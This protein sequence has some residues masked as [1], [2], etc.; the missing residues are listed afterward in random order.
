MKP[1]AKLRRWSGLLRE[2]GRKRSNDYKDDIFALPQVNPHNRR[3]QCRVFGPAG[4][5]SVI[6]R[7]TS[8]LLGLPPRPGPSGGNGS[9]TLSALD[10]WQRE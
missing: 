6:H 3:R 4:S 9:A 7:F 1:H 5:T 10:A 2:S 8:P